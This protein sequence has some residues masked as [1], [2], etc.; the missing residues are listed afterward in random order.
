M[1]GSLVLKIIV[2]TQGKVNS[3]ECFRLTLP[4]PFDYNILIVFL[5]IKKVDFIQRCAREKAILP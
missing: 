3:A 1:E 2:F 4:L 5:A